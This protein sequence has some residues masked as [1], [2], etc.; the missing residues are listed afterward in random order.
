MVRLG[1]VALRLDAARAV[2]LALVIVAGAGNACTTNHD[3]LARQPKAGSSGGGAAGT[4]GF[5]SGGF[6]NTGNQASQGGRPN[7]DDEPVGDDV[8]TIVNGIVDAPS[9]RLCFARVDEDGETG[10]LAGTPLP[11]LAYSE[12]TVL[13]DIDGLSLVGDVIQPWV[14]SGEL[15][16][17]KNL[18]CGAAVELAESEEAKV[19]PVTPT[20][21]SGGQGGAADGGAAGENGSA[22][23]PGQ[24]PLQVPRLRARPL[25]ALPA[26]TVNIGRSILMVLTGCI[27]G[28]AYTDHVETAACG[29]GYSPETPTL[30]PIVVKLSRDLRFDK[31]GL[32]AVHASRATGSLDVRASGEMGAVSLVFASSVSYGSI[33]PRPA[34]TRF[35]PFE[36][37]VANFNYGLQA[38]DERGEVAYQA[39]WSDILASSGI[40]EV[41]AARTYT[42]IFL[43]P[44]PLLLKEGWWNRSAFAIVDNDPTRAN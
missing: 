27:G 13:T 9:V 30:Q 18:D 3:A 28:A 41:V 5:G 24:A 20:D 17:V 33:E 21:G 23:A 29:P 44:D 7:P 10:E 26:G 42:A 43:G 12:S 19:T 36:L 38:V 39:A 4:S 11:E 31:V 35:T 37:G 15:S 22:G 8:L 1:E 14:I 40:D 6:G 16:L 2:L 32:Q 25:A 34:D